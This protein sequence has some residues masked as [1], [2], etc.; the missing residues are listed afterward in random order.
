[1]TPTSPLPSDSEARSPVLRRAR[2]SIER[3]H[4]AD[5]LEDLRRNDFPGSTRPARR[6]HEL[7]E[8]HADALV[9]A[10]ARARRLRRR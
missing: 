4:R 6:G 2:G 8:A 1:M 3:E 5:A 7:D 10:E 9:A